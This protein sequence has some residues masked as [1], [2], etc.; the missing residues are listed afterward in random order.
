VT[1]TRRAVLKGTAGVGIGGLPERRP[2]QRLISTSRAGSGPAPQTGIFIGKYVIIFG[3]G[4]GL[5]IYEGTPRAGNLPVLY[6]TAPGVLTDPYGNALPITTGGLV[7]RDPVSGQ[8]TQLNFSILAFYS[9]VA[10]WAS[11]Q[12]ETTS[13]NPLLAIAATGSATGIY[14]GSGSNLADGLI[15]VPPSGDTT[16]VT[17]LAN[18]DAAVSRTNNVL[19]V[20]G[21]YYLPNG[22]GL[23]LRKT[24]LKFNGAGPRS[25]IIQV[26]GGSSNAPAMMVAGEGQDIGGFR[27]GYNSQ[28][29][30]ANTLAAA[31]QF[32]DDTV[33][34]CFMSNFHDMEW[35]QGAYGTV[36]NPNLTATGGF[37]SCQLTNISIR[38]WSISGI[39]W[40][41]AAG[42]G[43]SSC[44]GSSISNMYVNNNPAG[45]KQTSASFGIDIRNFVEIVFN[46][47]NLENCTINS[48]DWFNFQSSAPVA[49]F[50]I[51]INSLHCEE[52]T[53]AGSSGNAGMFHIGDGI[54]LE[55][56]GFSVFYATLN[57]TVWNP[58]V[59]FFGTGSNVTI[60]G[61]SEGNTN[62]FGGA[63]SLIHQ[64]A[65]FNLADCVLD[66]TDV[67]E[68]FLVSQNNT[69]L[70][71]GCYAYIQWPGPFPG[72]PIIQQN[73]DVTGQIIAA[74]GGVEETWH[75]LGALGIANFTVNHGRYRLLP[76]GDV[77]I[78]FSFVTTG[79]VAAFFG[80][81]ANAMPAAYQP[82]FIRACG[83][84]LTGN[85]T[86]N[87]DHVP[88][89]LVN[90][91]G[92][93]TIAMCALANGVVGGCTFRY[94]TN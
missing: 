70:A 47:L 90:T 42:T 83:I 91:A 23:D 82:D 67:A 17:D 61:F 34:N 43:A 3:T 88:S 57:G 53:L 27:I 31:F 10:Q 35:F 84:G 7:S 12:L 18:I 86:I 92:V 40:D 59:R 32:G 49:P 24:G 71:A 25:T 5:F 63:S 64:W 13:S 54:N 36:I 30:A 56:N 81:F 80:T 74:P 33:G 46:Q 8:A 75:T 85:E 14:L 89:I 37:F 72:T 38:G 50:N 52:L 68:A 4:G 21:T 78:D 48:T 94:P 6:E 9:G 66:V 26:Q 44:T 76:D 1:A 20:P 41:S 93:V 65:A 19:L 60:N 73:I 51:V 16:G 39:F 29:P 77:E 22:F 58:V 15:I 2:D 45:T 55:L 79:A 28:Q 87:P 11:I 69:G 62:A